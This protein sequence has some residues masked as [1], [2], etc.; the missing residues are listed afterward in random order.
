[1][2]RLGTITDKENFFL[3]VRHMLSYKV[4]TRHCFKIGPLTTSPYNHVIVTEHVNWIL[5]GNI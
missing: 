1:M 5:N 4:C 2:Y 3:C